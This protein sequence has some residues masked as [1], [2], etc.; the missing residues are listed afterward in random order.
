[1]V[2][3][4]HTLTR[5]DAIF[6]IVGAAIM[7]LWSILSPSP[8]VGQSI[9]IDNQY[10][11]PPAV[12]PLPPP[13]AELLPNPPSTATAVITETPTPTYTLIPQPTTASVHSDTSSPE[14]DLDLHPTVVIYHAPGWTLFRNLYMSNGTLYILSADPSLFPEIRMMTSSGLPADNTPENMAAREPTSANMDF[15]SFEKAHERWGGDSAQ[16]AKHRVSTIQGNT[17]SCAELHSKTTLLIS[18]YVTSD[19]L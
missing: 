10:H 11:S 8:F 15:I 6:V 12:D 4:R 2:I 17:V 3:P 18:S 14:F 16:G 13:P 7:H 19:A 9:V 1:M 5:K